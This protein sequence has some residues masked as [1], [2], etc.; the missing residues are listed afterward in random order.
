MVGMGVWA[1]SLGTAVH[2]APPP[3]PPPHNPA[4]PTPPAPPTKPTPPTTPPAPPVKPTPPTTPATP[5]TAQLAQLGKALFGDTTLSNPKGQS[6]ISCHSPQAGWAFPNSSINQQFGPVPGAVAGRFGNRKPPTISYASHLMQGPPAL[7]P[8]IDAYAGGFFDD[9]RADSLAAQIPG[10]LENPNEMNNTPAGVVSAVATGPSGAVFQQTFGVKI[11]TLSTTEAFNDIV[12]AIVAFES[13]EGLSPFSSKYDQYLDH[14]ATLTAQELA[15]LQLFTGSTTG[16][17]G[18]PPAAKNATCASCHAVQPTSGEAP[19][20]FTA[21]TFHNTGIPRNPNNPYY[22]QT[23]ATADP[24]GYNALGAA[25]IDYGLGDFLYAQADLPDGNV[26]KGSNGE[27]DYLKINGAFKTPTLR[28]VDARPNPTFVKCYGHNGF[29]KSLPQIVHFYN[30]RNL[31]SVPGEV[32]DFTKANPT[33][34]LKG[35]PLWPAPENP[36]AS[37]LVNPSGKLG[38]IGN[39]GLTPTDEANLVAFLRT[40]TDAPPGPPPPPPPAP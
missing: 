24:L 17:P 10:P 20:L 3:P 29:F 13:S 30:T 37:S 1:M 9:G 8:Q 22:A 12:E 39:L 15:G 5:T 40:L 4:P 19:D 2:A 18:G 36:W 32:I 31:T 6:C 28:N 16:R 33:A 14:E 27:G 26:G 7:I 11:T 34:G 38:Q 23:S 21:S 25:Y 35:K